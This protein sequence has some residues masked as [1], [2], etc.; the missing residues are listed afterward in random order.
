MLGPEAMLR[1]RRKKAPEETVEFPVAP[2]LDMSFQLLAFF[3]LTFQ[4]P[5]G[6]SRIDLY[7]P[8]APAALIA[9]PDASPGRTRPGSM[10]PDLETD[11]V[12]RAEADEL[13]DLVSLSLQGSE[14]PDAGALR[15]RL[16]RYRE[17]LLGEPVT[18]RLVADDRLRYE[19]AARIIGACSAAGVDAVRLA[20]SDPG[21]G[22]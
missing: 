2:M 8:S 21:A 12:V 17:Q 1:S 7:L 9:S 22:P 13:G 15:D 18:I 20:G 11:L 5:S 19:E 3:I 14:V 6:E 4:A 16:R 10:A